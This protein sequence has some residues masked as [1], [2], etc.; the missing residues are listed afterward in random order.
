MIAGHLLLLRVAKL[1][2]GVMNQ[3]GV[4]MNRGDLDEILF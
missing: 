1:Q 3:T 4:Y 2:Y